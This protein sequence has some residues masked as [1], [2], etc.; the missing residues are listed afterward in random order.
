MLPIFLAVGA[1]SE[2]VPSPERPEVFEKPPASPEA[3][4][5]YLAAVA[6]WESIMAST[7]ELAQAWS[8]DGLSQKKIDRALQTR[9]EQIG[10]YVRVSDDR[11]QGPSTKWG[12]W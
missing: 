12:G 2:I 10:I 5:N 6:A 4:S 9:I 3:G 11:K 1:A 7:L 8:R